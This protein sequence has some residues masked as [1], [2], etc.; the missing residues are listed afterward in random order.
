V[1]NI[2]LHIEIKK[3]EFEAKFFTGLKA[4][5]R[6]HKVLVGYLLPLLRRDL[7]APGIFHDKALTPRPK[8]IASMAAARAAG[9]H[10][11]SIDEEHGLLRESYD[12]FANLRYSAETLEQASAVMFWGPHDYGHMK[13]AYPQFQDKFHMTGNPRADLWR[14]DFAPVYD[15][16]LPVK[17]PYILFVSN[18][19]SI[20]G[21]TP[22]D[23]YISSMR[24]GYFKGPYDEQEFWY[25]KWFANGAM[26]GAEYVLAVRRLALEYPE[27]TIVVRPHPTEKP[28]VWRNLIGDF[29][30]V[31]IAHEGSATPWLRN[32]SVMVHNGCTTSME[33][34]KSGIPV[35]TYAPIDS[36]DEEHFFPNQLG[37]R[38]TSLDQ[39]VAS[40]GQH[41]KN[42]DRKAHE[43]DDINLL[44]QRLADTGNE[45]AADRMIAVWEGLVCDGVT[46]SQGF[47]KSGSVP[48]F[49]SL[50]SFHD[51]YR[52]AKNLPLETFGIKKIP[53][54][55]N[56]FEVL[57]Q[58]EL[59][60]LR[61]RFA[62]FDPA[63]RKV[64]VNKIGP[65]ICGMTA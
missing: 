4:A 6:G 14:P 57:S 43:T 11:T 31:V 62:R 41:L 16:K 35:L 5:L 60:N 44:A 13:K 38:V 33:A 23:D 36:H 26:L 65:R 18:L 1:A 49:K 47:W 15:V 63:F 53:S 24:N 25:Y 54:Y 59:E 39:L 32:A 61:D 46:R 7:L 10:Y 40:V 51:I 3:R 64:R 50:E 30:N 8:K 20:F 17:K 52:Y 28:S 19:G 42:K 21:K 45:T 58:K 2:Y 34:T 55:P 12:M 56:K 29:N 22:L 9:H 37:E 27:A 48:R